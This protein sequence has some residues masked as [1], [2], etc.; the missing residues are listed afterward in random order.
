M[1]N[2]RCTAMEIAKVLGISKSLLSYHI[3]KAIAS[4][5]VA[6]VGRDA[7]KIYELTQPGKNFLAMYQ[8]QQQTSISIC[9]AEKLKCSF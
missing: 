1:I 4:G 2:D 7:F 6:E 5:Y 3:K 8:Q 9:R